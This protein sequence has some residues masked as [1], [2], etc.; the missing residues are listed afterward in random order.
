MLGA[1]L[2]EDKDR[3]ASEMP[4]FFKKSKIMYKVQTKKKKM[5]VSVNFSHALLSVL[6]AH[7]NLV[8]QVSVWLAVVWC[9]VIR[10]GAGWYSAVWFHKNLT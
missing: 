7:D 2:P 1:S 3:A 6:P 10:S 4:S 8:M 9:R 5:I